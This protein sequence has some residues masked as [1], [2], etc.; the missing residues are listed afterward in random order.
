ML[1][2]RD[3]FHADWLNAIMSWQRRPRGCWSAD[4]FISG[5]RRCRRCRYYQLLARGKYLNRVTQKALS[6]GLYNSHGK[7]DTA[8]AL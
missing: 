5:R 6:V 4:E 8:R 2:Y 1:G 3:L 7:C